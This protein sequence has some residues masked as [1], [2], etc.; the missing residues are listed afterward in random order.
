MEIFNSTKNFTLL[1]IILSWSSRSLQQQQQHQFLFESNPS[2]KTTPD[3]VKEKTLYFVNEGKSYPILNE[4]SNTTSSSGCKDP[5]Y[6]ELSAMFVDALVKNLDML[7]IW[8]ISSS[9][10]HRKSHMLPDLGSTEGIMC[11]QY[12]ICLFSAYNLYYIQLQ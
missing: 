10:T 2:L 5:S 3:K 8:F 4:T 12:P 11:I 6:K 7:E 9:H 1:I